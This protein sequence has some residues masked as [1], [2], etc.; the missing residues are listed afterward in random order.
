MSANPKLTQWRGLRVWVLGA[1]SG[2]GAALAIRLVAA[3]AH[4]AISA[5]RAHALREVRAA[6]PDLACFACDAREPTQ[7]AATL[8]AIEAE[9]GPLDVA[10]YCAGVWTPA[11]T[12][13]FAAEDIDATLNCNVH[14][15]MHFARLLLPRMVARGGGELGFVSS[16]AGYRPLPQA[17]LYGASKAALAYFAGAL[18]LEARRHKLAVRLINPGFVDTPMTAVN[19]FPMPALIDSAT[20]AQAIL[21]GYAAG[22]FEIAFPKRLSW[23]LKLLGLLPDALYYPLLRRCLKA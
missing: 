3:G 6:A 13:Q 5:R 17:A 9:L 1:S 7:I 2:I 8:D 4:V 18:H 15:A 22:A 16:V 20:A 12:P 21:D 23:P 10:I 11:S 19:R 14:G